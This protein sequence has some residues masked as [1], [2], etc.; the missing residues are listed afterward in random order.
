[1]TPLHIYRPHSEGC[2]KEMFSLSLSVHTQLEIPHPRFFPRSLVL[3]PFWGGTA[4]L[5][6]GGTPVLAE[7]YPC[8]WVPPGLRYS[9]ARTGIH[10]P[11]DR[12]KCIPQD[13]GTSSCD[14]DTHQ[15]GLV[16]P[17]VRTRVCPQ[18]GLGYPHTP[19]RT[20]VFPPNRLCFGQ[21]AS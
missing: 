16:Y 1:M 4:V 9:P 2:G 14:W 15:P 11:P 17:L 13:F 6:Q 19:T 20:E 5:V 7:G 10:P 18:A 12:D 21:Y 3:G 8:T